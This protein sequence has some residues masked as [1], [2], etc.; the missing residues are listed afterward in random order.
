MQCCGGN[1]TTISVVKLSRPIHIC[2][3]TCEVVAC[4]INQG[5]CTEILPLANRMTSGYMCVMIYFVLHIEALQM[6][7]PGQPQSGK[8]RLPH[9][10]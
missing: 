7:Q 8:D 4:T 1:W 6:I 9:W 3:K 5:G 10:R 2:A